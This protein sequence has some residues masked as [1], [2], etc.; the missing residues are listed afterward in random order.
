MQDKTKFCV[1]VCVCVCV[2]EIDRE[3]EIVREYV[4]QEIVHTAGVT[5]FRDAT[6]KQKVRN[7][8]TFQRSI[9]FSSS[10]QNSSVS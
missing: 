7:V 4:C 1:C 8:Q 10:R 5:V 9:L 6:H 2:R 3:I